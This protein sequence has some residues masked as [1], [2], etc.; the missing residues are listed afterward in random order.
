MKVHEM[1]LTEKPFDAIV[2]GSKKYE[3]RL[4]DEKRQ[5]VQVGDK[6]VFRKLP[7]LEKK[8][9][10]KVTSLK[11]YTDF[12]E[13]F[14]DLKS[15]YPDWQKEDWI[16]GMY[17]YYDREDEQKYGALAIG[18]EMLPTFEVFVENESDSDQKNIYNEKTQEYIKT[19]TVSRKYPYAYGFLL[20]TTS[21]DGDNLD[22]FVIT[23]QPFKT[24]SIV[25]VEP[26]GLMEQIDDG[27]EDHNILAVPVGEVA[28]VNDEVKEKLTDFIDHV[29][30]HLDKT[31]EVGRFLG[32]DAALSEIE[33]TQDEKGVI[34]YDSNWQVEFEK[35]KQLLRDVF[36]DSAI[37]IEHIG[38][39]AVEG[40][41]AKPI[42]DLA[43]MI[44]D[45]A[46]ADK[47]SNALE[48]IGYKFH[49]K[50]T[51]RHFYQKRKPTAF[52]LSIAYA[53]RGGFWPRQLMFRDYLRSHP[54]LRDEYADL[55][56]DLIEK[57]PEGVGGYSEGKTESVQKV[58][59]LAGWKDGLTYN[60]WKS[61]L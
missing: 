28:A 32:I 56:K 44:P 60:E 12:G 1:K 41:A 4:N 11:S 33:K 57:Y 42:I 27:E 38:S 61:T 26:I 9:L 19:V 2:A 25:E 23:E 47:Y 24:G 46:D 50:S 59:D 54:D 16:E 45:H 15:E 7:D 6:I 8:L 31:V 52:N 35:E 18:I 43:V 3:L 40:L 55:K 14:D 39:T 22:C 48:Q 49:S 10:V 53:D 13:M 58:L 34:R 51:E 5:Q 37:E 30:D 21:G 17:K 20:D 36:G 29:F